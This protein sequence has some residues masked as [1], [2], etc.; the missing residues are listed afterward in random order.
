MESLPEEILVKIGIAVATICGLRDFLSLTR[1]S[2]HLRDVL[3][4]SEETR[5]QRA[6]RIRQYVIPRLTGSRAA[7]ALSRGNLKSLQQLH[8]LESLVKHNVLEHNAVLY[9]DGG[10]NHLRY[11]EYKRTFPYPNR[12]LETLNNLANAME[13]L[14]PEHP[15]LKFIIETHGI[16]SSQRHRWQATPQRG[17]SFLEDLFRRLERVMY[18][19]EHRCE[20]NTLD[21]RYQLRFWRKQ[22]SNNRPRARNR[23]W[24]DIF[25]V[26]ESDNGDEI[27]HPEYYNGQNPDSIVDE[28]VQQEHRIIL[29]TPP[30]PPRTLRGAWY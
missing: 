27:A 12:I 8:I 10:Y 20:W 18:G 13:E 28:V 29:S 3:W 11:N 9:L 22:I 2:K 30:A 23:G 14:I 25:F 1:T 6:I 19:L 26:L 4:E 7:Q 24:F 5:E 15:N 16:G 21:A 17:H